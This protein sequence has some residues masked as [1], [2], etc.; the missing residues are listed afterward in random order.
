MGPEKVP[1]VGGSLKPLRATIIFMEVC[2]TS[3]DSSPAASRIFSAG[4]TQPA[5]GYFAGTIAKRAPNACAA[6]R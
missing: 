4:A 5:F 3:L 1:A 2:D 6:R